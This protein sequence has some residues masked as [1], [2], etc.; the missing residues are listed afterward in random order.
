MSMPPDY[1]IHTRFSSDGLVGMAEMCQAA[2]ER[3]LTEI[4]FTEH[5]DFD[6]GDAHLPPYRV[7]A[8]WEEIECCRHMFRASLTIRAGI[9]LSEPH[10]YPKTI[11]GVLERFPWDYTLGALHWVDSALIFH[12]TYFERSAERAYL[13][14]FEELVRMA[15]TGGFDIL[16]HL[17]VVKRYAVEHY[18]PYDPRRYEAEIREILRSCVARGI[19]LEVNTCTLRRPIGDMSPDRIVIDWY[20]QA[21]G[22][23]LTLGSDAHLSQD[24]GAGF[25][26]AVATVQAAGFEHL[27]R[28]ER[29]QPSPLPLP[30]KPA[31]T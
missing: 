17:D 1:H 28:F 31:S 30:A 23:W 12:E 15:Q 22:R 19:A 6:P 13:D 9:E 20:R 26:R 3:G 29:R 24:V 5:L 25:D 10:R 18:G 21:G 4:G 16:A 7:E 14:Y 2:V 8:W 27:A 11:Q